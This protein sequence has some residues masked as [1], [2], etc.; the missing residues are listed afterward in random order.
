M[1]DTTQAFADLLKKNKFMRELSLA[2]NR[3]KH[4]ELAEEDLNGTSNRQYPLLITHTH[5][6][7]H[8]HTDSFGD[9][10]P[11]YKFLAPLRT[12]HRLTSLDLSGNDLG[13]GGAYILG[14]TLKKNTSL[15]RLD[16][17]ECCL[18][19]R[20]V[21]ALAAHLAEANA[22]SSL[23]LRRNAFAGLK[24]RKNAKASAK[25]V[26][27]LCG[28]LGGDR[29]KLVSLDLAYNNLGS[30][31]CIGILEALR[32]SQVTSLDLSLNHLCGASTNEYSAEAAAAL[33]TYVQGTPI[34]KLSLQWNFLQAKGGAVLGEALQGSQVE[35]VD[36]SR[37]HLRGSGLA[38]VCQG[39]SDKLRTLKA[40]SNGACGEAA[41]SVAALLERSST[42][43]H[44]DVSDDKIGTDGCAT[45]LDAA[46]RSSSLVS[47]NVMKNMI[48][49]GAA[50]H[51]GEAAK[52]LKTLLAGDND[53]G[54][55]AVAEHVI[56]CLQ[57]CK[58]LRTLS[59]WGG[60]GSM[61]T[62]LKGAVAAVTGGG[63]RELIELDLGLPL[64]ELH[65]QTADVNAFTAQLQANLKAAHF[66]SAAEL[67]I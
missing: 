47:L 60:E 40:A 41:G 33:A 13:P 14:A 58:G 42:L 56:P 18:G 22:L 3:T 5:T 49:A 51:V 30:E 6:H 26:A 15:T 64:T 20:G 7:T 10:Q 23:G 65:E 25:A 37:N 46:R 55:A 54:S 50:P 61:A 34:K 2:R 32:S 16:V 28:F 19:P 48:G 27:T 31:L 35:E 21:E 38:A 11:L 44:V 66:E 45:I 59:V 67:V 17:S 39:A 29:N 43:Q 8:T 1:M 12:F 53:F 36:V 9:D 57:E 4:I 63:C 62:C 52:H 24:G